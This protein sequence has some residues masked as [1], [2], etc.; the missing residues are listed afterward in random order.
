V[1]E[2]E[3][4][5]DAQGPALALLLLLFGAAVALATAGTAVI[6]SAFVEARRRAYEFA[7]LRTVGVATPSLRLA[8]TIETGVLLAVG[9]VLGIVCGMATAW[10]ATTAV[11]VSTDPAS[12]PPVSATLSWELLGV[13][14]TSAVLVLSVAGY[15][16]SR[17]VVATSRPAL[18]REAQA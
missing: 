17:H 16:I 15:L 3:A 7:A 11:P 5:L 12:G 2:R 6:A 9:T 13:A 14:A 4:E 1:R 8:A 10:L 18:L